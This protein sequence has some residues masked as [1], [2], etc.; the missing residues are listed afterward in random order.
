V[1]RVLLAALSVSALV[2]GVWAASAP[3]SFY[4]SFP[5]F[6]NTWV[7]PDGPYNQHLVRDVG[8]LN[9]ALAILTVAAAIVLSSALVRTAAV[10][11]IVSGG[12]H[13][14]YH[15]GHVGM[16]EQSDQIA[17]VGSLVLAPA[18]AIAILAL[19]YR[20]ASLDRT[21]PARPAAMM[22]ASATEP[23]SSSTT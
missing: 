19:T 20:P 7:S 3:R 13:L 16:F 18:A 22:R 11:W 5:G 14:A 15:A 6:G 8:E 4:D 10:A 21:A 12:L 17:I 1:V 23:S 2:V 9:L